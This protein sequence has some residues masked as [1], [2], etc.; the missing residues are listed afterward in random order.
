MATVAT[1]SKNIRYDNRGC[2]VAAFW[3]LVR[4]K[5]LRRD[6]FDGLRLWLF[7]PAAVRACVGSASWTDEEL[8]RRAAESRTGR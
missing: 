2:R 8:R 4:A 7:W 5:A 1:L 6:S 3:G